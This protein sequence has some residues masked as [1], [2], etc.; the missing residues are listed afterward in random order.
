MG[1]AAIG[2]ELMHQLHSRC[3]SLIVGRFS[4]GSGSGLILGLA[5]GF[6][7][8]FAFVFGAAFAFATGLRTGAL[9]LGAVVVGC[10]SAGMVSSS[11]FSFVLRDRY[12]RV[13]AATVALAA[14]FALVAIVSLA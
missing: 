3:V 5:L 8:A 4:A 7:L 12:G 9:F 13:G 2:L 10:G 6:A 14:V 11:V 1:Y